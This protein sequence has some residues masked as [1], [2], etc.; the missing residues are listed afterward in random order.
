VQH[1]RKLLARLAWVPLTLVVAGVT[2]V[3]AEVFVFRDSRGEVRGKVLAEF[4][5]LLFVRLDGGQSEFV[6]RA[7]LTAIVDE[8]GQRFETPPPG[9]FAPLAPRGPA[10]AVTDVVGEVW[11]V[12]GQGAQSVRRPLIRTPQFLKTSESVGTGDAAF[13]RVVLPD[14]ATCMLSPDSEL[15]FPGDRAVVKLVRGEALLRTQLRPLGLPLS[16]P[17]VAEVGR[18]AELHVRQDE[19]TAHLQ[20]RS[21]TTVVSA[22]W[23]SVTLSP[24]G[25]A[26]FRQLT[27][28]A[29]RISADLANT[30]DLDLKLQAGQASLAPG[31]SRVLGGAAA[32][33]GE[34]WR[35]L[36]AKGEIFVRKASSEEADR[37]FVSVPLGQ[38][39]RLVLGPEDALRTGGKASAT[40]VRG[41]DGA[42]VTLGSQSTVEVDS[43]LTVARG[44][45]TVEAVDVPVRV[46]TPVGVA[47][48]TLTVVRFTADGPAMKVEGVTGTS[49]LPLGS[50]ADVLLAQGARA[51]V[52]RE[53]A[54]TTRIE[55]SGGSAVVVDKEPKHEVFRVELFAGESVAVRATEGERTALLLPGERVLDFDVAPVEATVSLSPPRA[56]FPSGATCEFKAGLEIALGV[57]RDRP[58]L[59]FRKGPRLTLVDSFAIRVE[60]PTVVLRNP[61]GD[62]VSL[63]LEGELDARLMKS[64][65]H[66]LA[67]VGLREEDF[68]EISGSGDVVFDRQN[69]L[70]RFAYA[71][72]RRLWIQDGAP[73]V[74]S[75]FAD[76]EGLAFLTMPGVAALGIRADR[77]VTVLATTDGE[78]VILDQEGV[79]RELLGLEKL[80]GLVNDDPVPSLGRDPIPNLLD[81]PPPASPSGP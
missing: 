24:G 14:G 75:R 43:V 44:Q 21:G 73:A 12:V 25:G 71:G 37:P 51:R 15:R 57:S 26:S 40:L 80:S 76:A 18:A 36:A 47:P 16:A 33:E 46:A 11:T 77:L 7:A 4:D 41:A 5:D 48:V 39:D 72:G 32:P 22:P 6:H 2:H 17:L 38:Q 54:A 10:A 34:L 55:V 45:L 19:D 65:I 79:G 68:L 50:A 56:R 42:S 1:R 67:A 69:E 49:T 78:F 30:D 35:V 61:E 20:Q 66:G 59:I 8:G 63:K 13:G 23:L 62:E 58:Q 52:S 27:T 74:Q 70:T 9:T 28:G 29:W 64:G 81:V 60:N 31:E 3:A 53:D